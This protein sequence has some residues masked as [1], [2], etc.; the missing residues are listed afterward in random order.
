MTDLEVILKMNQDD[1]KNGTK[2]LGMCYHNCGMRKVKG[3]AE[4]S[5]GMPAE[6]MIKIMDGSRIPALVLIDKNE[7]F[8]LKHMQPETEST[9]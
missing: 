7:F 4:I 9:K 2:N 6:E 1:T 5:M 3:G 8:R